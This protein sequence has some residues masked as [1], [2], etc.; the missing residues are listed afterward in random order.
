MKITIILLSFVI[1]NVAS[2][3][4]ATTNIALSGYVEAKA[5]DLVT[6]IKEEL[7]A[8]KEKKM[9]SPAIAEPKLNVEI[10]NVYPVKAEVPSFYGFKKEIVNATLYD[11]E[12]GRVITDNVVVNKPIMKK[13][14]AI[15]DVSRKSKMTFNLRNGNEL[16]KNETKSL[17]GI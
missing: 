1:Y 9:I 10:E 2:L 6:G 8:K 12:K 4:Q 17:H 15:V 7:D 13:E 5:K 11:K 16:V 3:H 14:E